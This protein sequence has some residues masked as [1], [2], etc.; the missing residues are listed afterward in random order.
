MYILEIY[1]LEHHRVIVRWEVNFQ[2]YFYIVIIWLDGANWS[3]DSFLYLL[4]NLLVDWPLATRFPLAFW[5][6]YKDE[7][8]FLLLRFICAYRRCWR[9]NTI[10]T[11]V[12]IATW[13]AWFNGSAA[14]VRSSRLAWARLI[15][16]SYL[17]FENDVQ[18][19]TYGDT[20]RSE[21]DTRVRSYSRTSPLKRSPLP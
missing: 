4:G 21:T 11:W 9:V 19:R 20:I 1:A 3:R 14:F 12:A 8:L 10:V 2:R 15:A 13:V 7:V 6:R 16:G 18:G 17:G 5:I